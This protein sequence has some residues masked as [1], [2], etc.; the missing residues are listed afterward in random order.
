[1]SNL[2]LP[3][4]LQPLAEIAYNLWFSWNEEALSL[5]REIDAE[6][7]EQVHHNPVQLLSEMPPAEIDRLSENTLFFLDKLRQVTAVWENYR[8]GAAWFR[9]AHPQYAVHTIAYFFS[10]E[11]GFHESLPIY[12]G[13]LGV[14]AGDHCKAA[15]D[16]GVPLVG[17]GLLYKEGY[18]KQKNR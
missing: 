14:L 4:S 8:A 12:S 13:G 6:L 9:I 17:V 5:F 18:F 2:S 7:W 16:L 10:A 1:M 3:P 11:F 15:S